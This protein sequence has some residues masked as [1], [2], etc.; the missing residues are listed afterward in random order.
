M[1]KQGSYGVE[2]IVHKQLFKENIWTFFITSLKTL[3]LHY[4]SSWKLLGC[5]LSGSVR[6][7]SESVASSK[8]GES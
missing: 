4:L 2:L 1:E 3:S 8:T 6:L 5:I 7:L